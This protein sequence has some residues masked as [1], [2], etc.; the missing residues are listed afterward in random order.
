MAAPVTNPYAQDSKQ[1]PIWE[2]CVRRDLDGFL[3][4]NWTI[5]EGDFISEG[6]MGWDGCHS[7]NP[8][9]W[10][11]TYPNLESYKIAWLKGALDFKKNNIP[12]DIR[13]QLYALVS[14]VRIE[15]G[16]ESGLVHKKFSGQIKFKDKSMQSF[17]WQSIFLLRKTNGTWRQAGFIGY[18]PLNLGLSP[19]P[20]K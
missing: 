12:S 16:E 17:N 19:S 9:E 4:A 2:M 3:A 5:C 8:L 1:H 7:A 18:L 11:A 13:E 15:L 20:I 6:F 10:L 14:L